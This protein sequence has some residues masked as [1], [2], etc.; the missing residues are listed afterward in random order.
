[1]VVGSNLMLWKCVYV[2]GHRLKICTIDYWVIIEPDKLQLM[3]HHHV[4]KERGNNINV[5][6][7]GSWLKRKTD[8]HGSSI[9]Q[10]K[11]ENFNPHISRPPS[12]K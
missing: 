7:Q 5:D 11:G 10:F 6:K 1:M 2:Y 9:G 8:K 3:G 12:I 4:V